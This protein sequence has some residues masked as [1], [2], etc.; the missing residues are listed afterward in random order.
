MA[1]QPRFEEKAISEFIKNT[2]SGQLD[3]VMKLA[4]A[5]RTDLMKLLQG[6]VDSVSFKAENLVREDI[7]VQELEVQTDHISINPLSAILGKIR[8]DEPLDSTIRMVLSEADLNRDMNSEI[9]ISQL[10]PIDLNVAG[11]IVP[12]EFK[13]PFRIRL[14]R[15]N[16]I[17]FTGIMEVHEPA[18][19][20]RVAFTTVSSLRTDTQPV[21]LETF[22]CAPNQGSSVPFM[23]AFLSKLQ[24]IISQ[25]YFELDTVAVRVASMSIQ[26]KLLSAEIEIHAR[27]IPSM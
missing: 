18:N 25:P 23:I 19:T 11:Q 14:L 16:K 8:L 7:Q 22:C 17:R 2:L 26:N 1:D 20:R 4:V 10:K 5:V 9:A 3:G 13:P 6:E 21:L 27:Q 15:D 12:I 24:E